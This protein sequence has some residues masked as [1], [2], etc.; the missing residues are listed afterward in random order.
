MRC[1]ICFVPPPQD[2][3]TLAAAHWLRRDPYSGAKV[4]RPVEGL[5]EEDHAYVTAAPRRMG[6]HGLLKPPFS[7]VPDKRVED[8][9][10]ALENFA[11]RT[12][13]VRIDRMR[14]ALIDTFFALVPTE[15]S[16]DLDE[17]AADIVIGFDGFRDPPGEN[18]MRRFDVSRLDARQFA[19]LIAWGHPNVLDKFRFR[20]T[21]TGPIDAIERDHVA[22]VLTRHFGELA[23]A[24]VTISQVALFVEP[25]P[26]APF[27]VHSVH[28]L[29]AK[30]QRKIA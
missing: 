5:V 2:A 3:L 22:T 11:R 24:P 26:H 25:E 21:L 6:F 15:R 27:L 19:N 1:A 9:E 7:L 4:S 10:A 16:P 8:V 13:T 18:D 20:M 29:G 30:S 28:R 12:G 17:L 14:I 23:S